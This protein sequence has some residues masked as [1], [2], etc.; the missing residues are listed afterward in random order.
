MTRT[1]N[2][3]VRLYADGVDISGYSRQVGALAWTFGADQDQ[4]FTDQSKNVLVGQADIQAGTISA[5]LD[6]DAAGL[7]ALASAGVGT[8]NLC[9]VIGANAAPVAGDAVFA[10]QPRSG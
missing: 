4:S 9:V 2:K 1:H 10:P 7:Y 3:H 8:R 5:F 6:N